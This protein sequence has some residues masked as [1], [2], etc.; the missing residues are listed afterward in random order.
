M[1]PI[2]PHPH[3]D[4]G[5]S[6]AVFEVNG[7][8]MTPPRTPEQGAESIMA[9]ADAQKVPTGSFTTDGKPLDWVVPPSMESV[10]GSGGKKD[11]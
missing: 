9:A 6:A 1:H 3:A 8:K 4:M 7:Q 5:S 2:Q 11:E 10:A